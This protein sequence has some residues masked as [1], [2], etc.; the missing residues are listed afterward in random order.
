MILSFFMG[1]IKY[2]ALAL[3]VIAATFY[4]FMGNDGTVESVDNVCEITIT[5]S[6]DSSK[7]L[8]FDH[9]PT[10]AEVLEEARLENVYGF[11]MATVLDNN[12]NLYLSSS[13]GLISLNNATKDELESIKGIG[14]VTAK[15]IIEYRTNQPFL[16]VEEIMAV[17]GIGEKTYL[18]LREFLC[19]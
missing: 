7:T 15:K 5:L 16:T 8:S 19:L 10:I 2:L 11:E 6:G 12:H 9:P 18:K 13:P 3:L 4:D 17:S 1:K 14:P